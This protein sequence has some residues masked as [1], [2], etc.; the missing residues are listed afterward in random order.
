[1]YS[2]LRFIKNRVYN[3]APKIIEARYDLFNLIDENNLAESIHK[4]GIIIIKYL[5]KAAK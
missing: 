1:M 4:G 2:T 3:R 5:S